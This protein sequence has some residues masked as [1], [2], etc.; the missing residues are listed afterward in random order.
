MAQNARSPAKPACFVLALAFALPS[1]SAQA[2]E[3][4]D[5]ERHC[6]IVLNGQLATSDFTGGVGGQMYAL[7]DTGYG[8][9]AVFVSGGANAGGFARSSGSASASAFARASAS[10]HVFIGTTMGGH[11]SGHY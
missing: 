2:C 4:R 5:R 9:T 1:L 6:P 3:V 10:A 8:G 7:Y 11:G